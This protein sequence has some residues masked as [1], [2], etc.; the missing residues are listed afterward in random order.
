MT[1]SKGLPLDLAIAA[2][3]MAVGWLFAAYLGFSLL[4]PG[5]D[6]GMQLTAL[7]LAGL[8]QGAAFLLAARARTA[9]WS[10]SPARLQIIR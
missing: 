8:Y 7:V 4:S 3:L 1:E 5:S 2:V 6:H 10:P 9:R